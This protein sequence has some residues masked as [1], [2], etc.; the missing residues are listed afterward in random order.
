MRFGLKSRD[1][2]AHIVCHQTDEVR[3]TQNL[4]FPPNQIIR[5]ARTILGKSRLPR[6]CRT[7]E[8]TESVFLT[9]SQLLPLCLSA[10]L[11]RLC[12]G[13]AEPSQHM[14]QHPRETPTSLEHCSRR[15][16]LHVEKRWTACCR[17]FRLR[18][19]Q[20]AIS[21]PCPGKADKGGRRASSSP[22]HLSSSESS[23]PIDEG[24]SESFPPLE[25]A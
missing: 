13:R 20:P 15:H 4:D 12:T 5:V 2:L 16:Y 17:R 25:Q 19:T 18:Y 8:S 23:C 22:Q 10:R 6:P 9:T 3:L 11:G 14:Q 21:C 1:S 7:P 24:L